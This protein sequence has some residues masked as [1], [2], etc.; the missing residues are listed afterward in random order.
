MRPA[1]LPP[2]YR[3][4]VD[5][6]LRRS[7]FEPGQVHLEIP[8]GDEM[9]YGS[10]L[11]GYPGRP[12]AAFFRYV[13]SAL[14]TYDA[15]SQI[16]RHLGGVERVAPVLDFGS[17]WGR[18][19]RTLVQRLAPRDVWV[20]DLYAE[21]IGWQAETFGVNAVV[22]VT[23]PDRFALPQ[24]FGIVFA[25]SVFSH[26]PDGLFRGWL[27]RLH[28]A[29][30]EGGVLAFSVHDASFAPEGHAVGESGIGYEARSEST[31]HALDIY[32]MS[33]VTEAYVR[34][35]AADALGAGVEVR[36]F[37]RALFENQDLYVVAGPGV[38]LEGLSITTPPLV[39]VG[40]VE[41]G[42][43]LAGWALE[44]TPGARIVEVKLFADETLLGATPP[45]EPR[46]DLMKF[47][48]GA[49]NPPL[50]WRF[51]GPFPPG[52]LLRV[53]A[54]SATGRTA[55]GYAIPDAPEGPART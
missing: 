9:F 34:G 46:L 10:V 32:G 11:P 23:R 36:R 14:R 55:S 39:G 13:E 48:P 18:L 53:E 4:F 27:A 5:D 19:T 21:A 37:P 26:L 25:A 16:G 7:G 52:A 8:A 40:P 33:Y 1:D 2:A 47:F 3:G 54:T 15:W 50:A 30:A 42:G 41:A 43:P 44:P 49:P 20:S 45:G 24:R 35:A 22:S 6:L 12:G 28:A 38:S 51:E 29:V 17:G 31:T